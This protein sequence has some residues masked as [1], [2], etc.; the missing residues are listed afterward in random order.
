MLHDRHQH[1]S[2]AVQPAR[3][4]AA[5]QCWL[6]AYRTSYAAMLEERRE[7]DL[8][9]ADAK[10]A[11]NACQPDDLIDFAHLKHR[12]GVAQARFLALSCACMCVRGDG[13]R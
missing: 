6:E 13:V 4:G 3:C 1:L 7:R 5:A 11:A 2:D 10:A 8:E 9:E 12:R